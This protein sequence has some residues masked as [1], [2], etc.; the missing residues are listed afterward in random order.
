MRK[1]NIWKLI[2]GLLLMQLF[3]LTIVL[4]LNTEVTRSLG[5]RIDSIDIGLVPQIAYLKM[6]SATAAGMVRDNNTMMAGPPGYR[7]PLENY[8]AKRFS[9]DLMAFNIQAL[10]YE[11]D[12][13]DGSEIE[14]DDGLPAEPLADDLDSSSVNSTSANFQLFKGRLVTLYCTH[15][16]ESYV[17]NSGTVRN[18]GSSGL[19]T[20]VAVHLGLS[21][22]EKGLESNFINAVHDY[23]DFQKSYSNSRKTVTRVMA[24]DKSRLIALFDIHRDSIPGKT[25]GYRVNIK[26]QAAAPI[27]IIVGTDERK[28]HPN[29]RKNL[30]FAQRLYKQGAKDYPGLI[31]EVRTKSGTYN[32][33]FFRNSLL[34]EFGTDYNSLEE[35]LY[36]SEL[37]ADVLLKVLKEEL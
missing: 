19:I 1:R 31:K 17:P 20:R 37:F 16:G 33:E 8:A 29:W 13:S 32:Q 35:C 18:E 34:L 24:A 23:P 5:E 28:A 14:P 30:D 6:S 9:Q 21:L 11:E 10:D 2:K 7:N 26:G 36:S 3:A 27:L 12:T 15:S 25:E 4:G 22:K